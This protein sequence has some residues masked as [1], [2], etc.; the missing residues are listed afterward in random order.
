MIFFNPKN[1]FSPVSL[2]SNKKLIKAREVNPLYWILDENKIKR[3]TLDAEDSSNKNKVNK[4][5]MININTKKQVK[6]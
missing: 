1:E 2:R 5:Q 3:L 4:F 6:T